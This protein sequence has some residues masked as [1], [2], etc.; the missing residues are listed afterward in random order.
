M[1]IDVKVIEDSCW[2]SSWTDRD[3]GKLHVGPRITT[4]Q[5]MYPRII[6]GEFLTHR[7][8]SRNASSSRA[9]P[10]KTAIERI[11]EDPFIP[12]VWGQNQP[13]MQA[14]E[15]ISDE[16][17]ETAKQHWLAAM[18]AAIESAKALGKIGVHKQH[19]ARIL[20]P[21]SHIH[22][23]VTA[24]EDSFNHFFHLRD[25][26]AAQPEIRELARKMRAALDQ[27]K[28]DV[29]EEPLDENA[30]HIPYVTAEEV[31]DL[32]RRTAIMC[33]VARCARVSYLKHDNTKPS[34]GDDIA[35]FHKLLDRD[36]IHA[37][38]AEHIAWPDWN[39]E[40]PDM[41]GNLRG[42]IQFRKTLANEFRPHR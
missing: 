5:L 21:W 15:P 16:Q 32:D 27:S 6:H 2:V 8:F 11:L 1:T 39:Y 28:P 33:S 40:N 12:S 37:S 35:L 41:N 18:H 24:N 31:I 29:I 36:D 42:W 13:G 10:L 7:A 3:M 34:I 26:D 19:A 17:A 9:V 25:S 14:G 30:I 38:P 4:L 22:V 23:V 20:E